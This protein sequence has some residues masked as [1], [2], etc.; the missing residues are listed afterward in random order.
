MLCAQ[1]IVDGKRSQHGKNLMLAM[2]NR[3]HSGH[4]VHRSLLHMRLCN[5]RPVEYPCLPLS[6]TTLKPLVVLMLCHTRVFY[7]ILFN[8]FVFAV[9]FY[10]VNGKMSMAY[11]QLKALL[12]DK[13]FFYLLIIILN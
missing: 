10:V 8:C 5:C 6:T 1:S 3:C 9:L 11:L 13:Y 4:T 12:L 7:Y 2:I